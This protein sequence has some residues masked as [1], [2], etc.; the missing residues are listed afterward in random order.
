MATAIGYRKLLEQLQADG[1]TYMF[2]NPGSSEEGLLDAIKNFPAI[3]YILGLQEAALVLIANGYAQTTQRPTVV[4]LHCSVGVGNGLGSLYQAFRKQRTPLVVIAGEAGYAYDALEPHMWLDLVTF[5]RPVTK[6]AARAIHPGSLLRLLRR[7]IKMAATPPF[8]PTFLAVPQDILDQ[9]NDEPVLPTVVPETRVA[10]EPALIARAAELL[11]GAENPVIIMGDGVSQSQAYDELAQLAEV[12]GAGVWGAMA[13]EI[14]IPWTHPLYRGLTGHMFGSSSQRTVQDADA[15]VI[16]GTYVF[17]D[18]F[19]LLENPFR[20]GAKVVHIDLDPY[21]IA[22]NHPVTLGLASDPKLTMRL[23]AQT[24]ADRL[25]QDQKAAA[26]A[27]AERIGAEKERAHA[28][29]V[30][31]DSARREAV[32]LYMS[33]FAEELA[34]HLPKD[35][36]IYDEALTNSAALTRYIPPSTPGHLYQTPGG[37]LGVGIP[38]AIGVK[39]AHPDRTVVGF[40]GDGGA[41]FTY[42][43][44]WTAAHYRVGA[45]FVVCNNRSYRILKDNLV[46][47]WREHN[48][49]PPDFPAAFD[50]H[51]PDIDYVSL[52]K[53]LGVPGVRVTR[54]GEMA[55]VIRSML[56]HDGP[57]LVDL[58]LE[59]TVQR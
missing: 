15:V 31:S 29:Q 7:C 19:P 23:L 38:G 50:I 12:L 49:N 33:A 48:V 41:V 20:P 18:V 51:E 54:P 5:V 53:G 46:V 47:Y 1:M 42:P 34:K 4:Q 44:L 14:N 36:I 10:P 55:P 9:Q 3:Q 58:I 21:A 40:T 27:R 24:L 37:T 30:Q 59:D 45:K 16:C 2:G 6:Y 57:F 17:P 56:E 32:P 25:T 52:A 28:S 26:R 43:A 39:L 8:G 35:V 13:S 11:A 22:K